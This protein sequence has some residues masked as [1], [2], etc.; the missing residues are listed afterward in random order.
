[1]SRRLP[2]WQLYERARSLGLAVQV[3]AQS[4]EGLAGSEDERSRVAATAEGG[5]WLL[6]TPRP[7]AVVAMA[8][9]QSTVDTSRRFDGAGAWSDDGLSRTRPTP[10]LD[11][12]IVRRLEVGQVAYVYRGGVTFLQIKRLTGT[13]AAIGPGM[14]S[15]FAAG[16]AGG[17]AGQL[18][19]VGVS[20]EPPTIPLPV[21]GAAPGAGAGFTRAEG[22]PVL[23][24]SSRPPWG[25]VPPATSGRPTLPD[26]SEVLDDAFGV[27][28]D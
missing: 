14:G 11:G 12:D 4:W 24:G 3:S 2:I 15:I 21:I 18:D 23:A 7:D 22:S 6:R 13:Q 27:R 10:V 26:V 8:G 9:T 17:A 28:R 1:V 16:L 25:P 19:G 20:G 5:I